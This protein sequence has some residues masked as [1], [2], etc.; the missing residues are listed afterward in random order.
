M[1]RE[2]QIQA[3]KMSISKTSDSL[4]ELSSTLE[5]E[6]DALT[7]SSPQ[8]LESVLPKKQAQLKQVEELL[9]TQV[10]W[11]QMLGLPN[12]ELDV[13]TLSSHLDAED[14]ELKKL[15]L[16]LTSITKEVE[17]KN[18]RNGLLANQGERLTRTTLA[19]LTGRSNEQ[20]TYNKVGKG[21]SPNQHSIAKA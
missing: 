7:A 10:K 16:E 20:S 2:E 8:E 21:A 3:F 4:E 12:S 13:E 14:D 19:L 17:R 1:N 15:W 5:T 18:N 6:F 9:M 11:Q